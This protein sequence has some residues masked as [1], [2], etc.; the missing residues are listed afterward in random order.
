MSTK[1][2]ESFIE[3]EQQARRLTRRYVVVECRDDL[4]ADTPGI[5]ATFR[6]C[7]EHQVHTVANAR[8]IVFTAEVPHPTEQKYRLALANALWS[9]NRAISDTSHLP[10]TAAREL[11]DEIRHTLEDGLA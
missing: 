9:A 8:E 10:C 4:D 6:V 11:L 1:V 7:P 5:E 2:F 3:A